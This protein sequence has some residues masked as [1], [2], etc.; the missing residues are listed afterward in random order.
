MRAGNSGSLWED[1]HGSGAVYAASDDQL[2]IIWSNREEIVSAMPVRGAISGSYDIDIARLPTDFNLTEA[3]RMR[4][5]SQQGLRDFT[6]QTNFL[7]V[8]SDF[9]E[10]T[11]IL[12]LSGEVLSLNDIELMEWLVNTE[13]QMF[14]GT[15]NHP[16][17]ET[18][19]ED[20]A[21]SIRRLPNGLVT[22][23]EVP[24]QHIEN[25]RERMGMMFGQETISGTNLTVETPL[26]CVM[27]YF[28]TAMPGGSEVLGP[29]R[30]YDVTAFLIVTRSGFSYGLWSPAAGLFT[31]YGFLAPRE[32]SQRADGQDDSAG[33][34]ESLFDNWTGRKDAAAETAG[35]D[36]PDRHLDTYI[37]KAFD[38]LL[39]QVSP[40]KMEQLRLAGFARIIWAAEAGLIPAVAA[41]AAEYGVEHG[42]EIEELDMPLDEAATGGLLF[43][44]FNF[45][46][47][48]VTGA[49]ILPPVNLAR[50]L[51]MLADKNEVSRRQV[52]EFLQVKMHNRTVFSLWAAP[53]CVLAGLL[54]LS[55]GIVFQQIML[56]VRDGQAEARTLE[57]KPA[58][59]RRKSYEDTL[60][61]YQEFITQVSVLRKQQ[62]VGI[63]MMYE[64][65]QGL[66]STL[67]PSFYI[68]E[69]KLLPDGSMEMK[70]LARNKDAVTSFLRTLE[71]AAGSESGSKLF[72]K[73]TYEVQEGVAVPAGQTNPVSAG[74]PAPI[75]TNLAPGI[76]AWNIRGS[77]SPIVKSLPP[78]PVP[79]APPNQPAPANPPPP[80]PPAN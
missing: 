63:G 67:D 32:I 60:K 38:Q 57:L 20:T 41:V 73:L 52:E 10:R 3:L 46:E 47:D 26:R 23:T 6:E 76:I 70:G 18:P 29:G 21:C 9:T 34:D 27:R 45:G 72:D 74:G 55:I 56:T 44:S 80:P 40:E 78:A 61:W 75:N 11:R 2:A 16:V 42:L 30:E 8:V 15:D 31:E 71:F 79:N 48:T 43:G 5:E 7:T 24:R 1:D 25:I 69:M 54:A 19:L 37:R 50:D 14:L 51:L 12:A 66:P 28:L 36:I 77:Y 49:E 4:R 35:G 39:L 59:E 17:F 64:I 62:P 13:K 68:S 53:V 58:L 33:D 65:N 22:M